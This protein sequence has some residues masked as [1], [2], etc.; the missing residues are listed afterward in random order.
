[1]CAGVVSGF[2][3]VKFSGSDVLNGVCVHSRI[4]AVTT[5]SS[6]VMSF[7]EKKGWNVILSI[8]VFVPIGLEDPVWC[9]ARRCAIIIAAIAMGKK[10]C[11]AKNRV[12]VGCETENPPHIHS[13]RDLPR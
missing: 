7:L 2:A 11:R 8:L 13:T 9:S 6:G 5:G 3:S 4:M 1:M 10:K 12:R